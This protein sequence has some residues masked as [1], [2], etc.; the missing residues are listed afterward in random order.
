ML[1][2]LADQ[3]NVRPR[4]HQLLHL[5]HASFFELRLQLVVE[6]FLAQQIQG[7]HGSPRAGPYAPPV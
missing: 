2:A 4:L 1:Q 6:E 5:A 7:G 3:H